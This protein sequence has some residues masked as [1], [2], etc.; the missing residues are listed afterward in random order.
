MEPQY[1]V[2]RAKIGSLKAVQPSR[3]FQKEGVKADSCE[4]ERT[5]GGHGAWMKKKISRAKEGGG[6]EKSS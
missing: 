1:P 2:S 6:A 3:Q 5:K 4:G